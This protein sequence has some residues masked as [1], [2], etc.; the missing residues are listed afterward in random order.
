MQRCD[1]RAEVIEGN[2]PRVKLVWTDAEGALE[3][4]TAVRYQTF[5]RAGEAISPVVEVDEAEIGS[6]MTVTIPGEYL[7]HSGSLDV[8]QV[9][10]EIEGTFSGSSDIHTGR[11]MFSV[12][13]R[14]LT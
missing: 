1:V 10:V 11:V 12:R 2:S 7:P 5:T 9:V 6:E 14:F 3:T 8:C 13:N 4:P